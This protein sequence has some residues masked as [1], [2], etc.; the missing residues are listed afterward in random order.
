MVIFAKGD[1]RL[2]K[3]LQPQTTAKILRREELKIF[4]RW[5]GNSQICMFA[6]DL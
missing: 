2:E 3:L 4:V 1:A 6:C 5:T